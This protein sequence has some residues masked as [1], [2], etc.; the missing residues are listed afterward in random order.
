MDAQ[1]RSLALL[2]SLSLFCAVFAW[3]GE[4]DVFGSVFFV[5]GAA[6]ILGAAYRQLR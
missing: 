4:R 3:A 5:L 2:A 6:A 1:T